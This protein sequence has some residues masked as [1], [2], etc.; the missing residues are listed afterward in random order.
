MAYL[1]GDCPNV[2]LA[3]V[4][5]L[6]LDLLNGEVLALLPVYAAALAFEDLWPLETEGII[7]LRG[8]RV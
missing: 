3:L 6:L 4:L 1:L 7:L 8:Q 2:A 5:L